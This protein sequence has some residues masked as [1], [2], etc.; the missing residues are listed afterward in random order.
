MNSEVKVG[1]LFF[2]GLGLLLWFTIFV[3][4]IG[5]AKGSYA[6]HFPRVTRLKE[7][8]QV[9]YNG[10]RVGTI[11]EVAPALRED[12]TP[13][14]RISFS[15]QSERQKLVLIDG[16]TEFRIAQGLLGGSALDIASRSGQPISPE[17]LKNQMGKEPAGIDEALGSVMTLIEENRTGIKEAIISVKDGLDRFGKMS[18]EIQELV[19]E[20]RAEVKTAIANFGEMSERI[21]KLV[22]ENREAVKSAITRFDEMSTQI[23]DLVKENRESIKATADKLPEAVDNVSGA[24]KSIKE[25]VDENRKDIKTAVTNIAEAADK[26]EK[27]GAN[28]EVITD[29]IASGKGTVGKLVF[30]DQLHDKTL[31][32]VENFNQR[33][34][35]IK[36]VT[37]NFSDLRFYL[38][39]EGGGDMTHGGGVGAAYLR[40]EPRPWKYYQ[41]GVSYRMA[42]ADREVLREDPDKLNIDFSLLIGWRFFPDDEAQRY[43]LSVGAGLIDSKLGGVVEVPLVGDLG[44][45]AMA[46]QKDSERDALDRRYEDGDVMVRAA[47]TFRV[48]RRISIFAGGNDL[49]DNPGVW[50]GL[51]AELLDNDLRNLTQV[52]SL[53]P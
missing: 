44:L 6:V 23:R 20:N 15:I 43:R 42:P 36:P 33:M 22:E 16:K 38:G 29:Q 50:L 40:I 28:L 52:T 47:L 12:G 48:W 32:A 41:A 27:V 26:F 2:I 34:E 21:A 31:N 35:E 30:D 46:R 18:T 10:V 37:S 17:L 49:A 9:T 51:R 5:Q 39:V 14:V 25:T 3:T 13:L 53:M 4:Q 8:D 45:Y 19:K 24:A 7:G 11:T 1:I